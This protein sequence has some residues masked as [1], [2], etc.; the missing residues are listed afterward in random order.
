MTLIPG[1]G[2]VF[3]GM[4]TTKIALRVDSVALS[5]VRWDSNERA[6]NAAAIAAYPR[7]IASFPRS[8]PPLSG[9]CSGWFQLREIHCGSSSRTPPCRAGG[10]P[11][12]ESRRDFAVVELVDLAQL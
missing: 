6:S 3:S 7:S 1:T 4:A 2:E 9:E 5:R 11:R 12:G 8:W 10:L